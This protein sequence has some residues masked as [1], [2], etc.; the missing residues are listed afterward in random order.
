MLQF[1]RFLDKMS[2][3]MSID[4]PNPSKINNWDLEVST[5]SLISS[6]FMTDILSEFINKKLLRTSECRINRTRFVNKVINAYGACLERA[7]LFSEINKEYGSFKLSKIRHA[8]DCN[9]NLMTDYLVRFNDFGRYGRKYSGTVYVQ[10]F[11]KL[12]CEV[13]ASRLKRWVVLNFPNLSRRFNTKFETRF[14]VISRVWL[15]PTRYYDVSI[16]KIHIND[17]LLTGIQNTCE[18]EDDYERRKRHLRPEE[19]LSGR[20]DS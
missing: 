12:I 6:V 20:K 5:R 2:G 15:D 17:Y 14:D 19:I 7:S 10:I 9:G 16:T 8:H 3:L 11:S 13:I 1:H 18:T 4:K